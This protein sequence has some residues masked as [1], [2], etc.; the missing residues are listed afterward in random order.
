VDVAQDDRRVFE[1]RTALIDSCVEC[2]PFSSL[3]G[4]SESDCSNFASW[5]Q[6][7]LPIDPTVSV[8][9]R[10]SE[11]SA[12]GVAIRTADARTSVTTATS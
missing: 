5:R 4:I 11:A 3:S 1:E 7:S 9:D 6:I 12:L 2:R 8:T 10:M